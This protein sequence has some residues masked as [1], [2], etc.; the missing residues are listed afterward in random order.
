MEAKSIVH[1]S[2]DGFDNDGDVD[3]DV[4]DF[5]NRQLRTCFEIQ[6]CALASLLDIRLIM[7][8]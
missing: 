7:A 8:I 6:F 3:V 5:L 2:L 1:G 4:R